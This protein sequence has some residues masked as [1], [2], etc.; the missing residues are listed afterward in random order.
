MHIRDTTIASIGD[1]KF[2]YSRHIGKNFEVRGA[3]VSSDWT[4][5]I[6]G[7]MR[8]SKTHSDAIWFILEHFLEEWFLIISSNRKGRQLLLCLVDLHRRIN[9]SH[10]FLSVDKVTTNF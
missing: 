2:L 8:I 1:Q 3:S 4:S 10:E 9:Y 5:I 6:V 7:Q